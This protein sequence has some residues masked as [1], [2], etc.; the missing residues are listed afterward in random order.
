M[1]F[2]ELLSEA[3]VDAR[4]RGEAEVNAVVCD[5]RQCR[6]G[7]C[8]V[9]VR[10]ATLDGHRYIA[11]AAEAGASAIV[12]EDASAVPDGVAVGQVKNSHISVGLLAQAILGRPAD[13]LTCIGVTG[14]NGKTTVAHLVHSVLT[15]AGY[16][17]AILGTITYRTGVREAP[18]GV[19][20]PDA[21]SLAGMTEEMVSA[22]MTHLVMEVSSHA[23][24]Q[25]RTSG[26]RFDAGVFTNLSGDHLDYHNTMDHYASAKRRLFGGDSLREG[27]VAVINRDDP[28]AESIAE[29]AAGEIVWYGLNSAADVWAKIEQ[30]DSSG[31]RFYLMHH[32]HSE[33]VATP[34]IGRHNIY[35]CLAAAAT[36]LSLGIDRQTVA[37]GLRKV[38][39]VPGRLE[40][41]DPEAPYSV[42][43]DY[44][45]TDDALQN[46]LGSLQP[47]ARGRLIVVFGCGGDRDRTKRPRMA[48]VAED[49]ADR[50]VITSDNPRTEKPDE[51]IEQIVAGL[52]EDGRQRTEICPDRRQAIQQAVEQAKR[53][54]VVLIAGK[55][56]ETYQ[57][58]G[59]EKIPFDD[60]QVAR[61]AMAAR[62]HS[63]RKNHREG[64]K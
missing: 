7:S 16:C 33:E 17:P 18:A 50:I 64:R 53:G 42:F 59:T 21:V 61:S 58:V 51:I 6:P 11:E 30:I 28:Y 40:P 19:T 9:A 22:G 4:R 36:C 32:D 24:D 57:V 35:N 29:A 2:S 26:V 37:A 8:F 20:T 55:G 44:A 38:S 52:S 10:G 56:H 12:C 54:D 39:R 5:S 15:E 3:G 47:L 49:L 60:V 45:H 1:L 14:T 43:V 63:E 25:H 46:V 23:L 41:V 62:E 27:G 13:K 34:L 48:R 31:S